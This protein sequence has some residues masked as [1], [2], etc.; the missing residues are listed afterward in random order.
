MLPY[1]YA[2]DALVIPPT[3][4]PLERVG[5]TVLPIKTYLYLAIGRPIVAAATADL[6]EV[7]E[8]GR[9]AVLVPPDDLDAAILAVRSLM[10]SSELCARLGAEARTEAQRYTWD[11]RAA[12]ISGFIEARL[13]AVGD[14]GSR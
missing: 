11:Q 9:N 2:A 7:L 12:R 14:G 4:G 5:N 10:E 8:D 13:A 3:V 1:L 6:R